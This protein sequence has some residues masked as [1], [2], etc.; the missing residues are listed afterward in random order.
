MAS[1]KLP[2]KGQELDA[3]DYFAAA[4]DHAAALPSIYSHRDYALTI[5]V[6]GLAVECLFRAFRARRGLQFRSDHVLGDL[7]DEAG[8]PDL[9][10]ERHRGSVRCGVGCSDCGMAEQ[11]SIP[12]QRSDA[13][14]SQRAKIGPRGEG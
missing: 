6:A 8:F 13:T 3:D 9:L 14:I 1:K 10:P 5:Y 2:K 12:V 4:Q 7:G 11:P